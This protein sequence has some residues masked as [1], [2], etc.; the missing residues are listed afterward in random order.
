[1]L[2]GIERNV[3]P[4]SNS[5]RNPNKFSHIKDPVLQAWNRA[6]LAKNLLEDLGPAEAEAYLNNFLG[7][8]G[9]AIKVMLLD[10]K[11]RGIETVRAEINKL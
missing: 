9:I 11:K 7:K 10:I 5:Y 1:M 6:N 2:Q 8:E 3:K 4:T